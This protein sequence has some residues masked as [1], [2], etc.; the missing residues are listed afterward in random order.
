MAQARRY[1]YPSQAKCKLVSN[2]FPDFKT[3]KDS[4]VPVK[5]SLRRDQD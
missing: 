4:M 2:G 3:P 1:S 5:F